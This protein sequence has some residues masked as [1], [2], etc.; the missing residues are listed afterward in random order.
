MHGLRG[1][2]ATS[3]ALSQRAGKDAIID[4]FWTEDNI[5][6]VEKNFHPTVSHIRKALN[7]KQPLKQN[8][9]IYRDGDYQLNPEFSYRIDTEEFDR[10]VS[11]GDT[12]RRSRNDEG[13]V[14]AYEAGA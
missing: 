10:L 1:A 13:F 5:E 14:S 11:E 6:T 7:S 3:C 4:T 2:R 12:A 9:I 8:F